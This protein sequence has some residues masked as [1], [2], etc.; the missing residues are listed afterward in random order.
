MHTWN[1]SHID[2]LTVYNLI[3]WVYVGAQYNSAGLQTG[4]VYKNSSKELFQL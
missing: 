3:V 2:I 1:Q 4:R